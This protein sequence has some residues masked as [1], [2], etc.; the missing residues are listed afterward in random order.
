MT[1]EKF[2]YAGMASGSKLAFLR[3]IMILT[4]DHEQHEVPLYF[5][6]ISGFPAA[7]P[8]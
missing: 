2:T 4:V 6:L 5:V 8:K 7:S 3:G 1:A